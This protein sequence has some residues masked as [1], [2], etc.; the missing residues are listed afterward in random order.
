MADMLDKAKAKMNYVENNAHEL[1]GKLEQKKKDAEDD[2][3][4]D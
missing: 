1:K 4:S 3:Q 2:Q